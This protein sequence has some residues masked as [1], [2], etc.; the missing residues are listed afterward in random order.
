MRDFLGL[1]DFK[2]VLGKSQIW[3]YMYM[4]VYF[5]YAF[6]SGLEDPLLAISL[7]IFVIAPLRAAFLMFIFY[8]LWEYVTTFSFGIT[9]VLLMQ[10]LMIAKMVIQKDKQKKASTIIE[11]KSKSLQI[12]LLVYM[13]VMGAASFL[14]SMSMTGLGFV[15]KVLI[16]FYAIHFM[17]SE[18][19]YDNLLKSVL[20]ILM[21]SA[22]IATIYGF[23]H[24]TALDRWISGLGD[25]FS[26]L[27]GTLGTTRMAFI[28]LTSVT[29][30][31]YYVKNV[32]VK[33]GG[34]IVFTA[35]TLMTI[36]L[37]AIILYGVII[38][39]YTLSKG[40]LGKVIGRGVMFLLAVA[41]TFPVWSK[42][43]I[44]QPVLYRI[45]FSAEAYES[46]DINKA[47]TG[48]EEIQENYMKKLDDSSPFTIF[49]GNAESAISSTGSDMYSHNTYIDILFF[50]GILGIILLVLYQG[51]KILLVRGQSYFYPLL[52]LKAILLLGAASVSV[53]SASYFMVLIF[54]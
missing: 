9:V 13:I 35:L 47:T 5:V 24:D 31:L 51:K 46:G 40:T 26:Q 7:L 14:V 32:I 28:Y 50:F 45:T 29:F 3:L 17:Y 23:Y 4:F 1:F 15:F 49:F 21:L 30:F 20:Q 44:V 42:F 53:M 54:I 33:A 16:T 43:D 18:R 48:R 39:I 34:I 52:S 41:L 36:S 10:L 8:L 11:R 22:L 19:S 2:Y 38:F 12:G 27:Y 25:S 6:T 37:T